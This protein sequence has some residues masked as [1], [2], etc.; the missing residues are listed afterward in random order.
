[1][2]RILVVA[3]SN[4]TAKFKPFQGKNHGGE[5]F[6]LAGKKFTITADNRVK[7]GKKFMEQY[8]FLRD[9]G[10]R[11]LIVETGARWY[12]DYELDAKEREEL[13]PKNP[14]NGK[15]LLQGGNI[16]SGKAFHKSY[17]GRNGERIP[18]DLDDEVERDVE[19]RIVLRPTRGRD[20]YGGD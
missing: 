16:L 5:P 14:R 7:I 18:L 9:D 11:A 19:G 20:I 15:Y 1:M 10:K 13:G 17:S 3:D 12:A 2:A 6:W 4:G 8:G